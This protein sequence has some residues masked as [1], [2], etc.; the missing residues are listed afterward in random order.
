MTAMLYH[1]RIWGRGYGPP[2][3]WVS[4]SHT[5]NCH[6]QVGTVNKLRLQLR[7]SL[8]TFPGN[9]AERWQQQEEDPWGFLLIFLDDS[10]WGP[11]MFSEL[12]DGAV[13]KKG[14]PIVATMSGQTLGQ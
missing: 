3:W 10:P 12:K 8:A 14:R 1:R 6:T 5:G 11:T 2:G 4:A 7:H 13:T 9:L